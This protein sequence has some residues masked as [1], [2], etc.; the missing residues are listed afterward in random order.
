MY[1]IA[2]CHFQAF[3]GVPF[4][5]LLFFP[6][7]SRCTH[8]YARVCMEHNPGAVRSVTPGIRQQRGGDNKHTSPIFISTRP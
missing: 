4:F 8:Y 3:D 7:E 5:G 6:S 2:A 1:C